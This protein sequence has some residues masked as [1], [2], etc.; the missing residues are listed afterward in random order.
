MH[1]SSLQPTL[2]GHDLEVYSVTWHPH[3]NVL[4]SGGTDRTVRVWDVAQGMLLATLAGHGHPQVRL[5]EQF[6]SCLLTTETLTSSFKRLY[7]RV[8]S[9]Y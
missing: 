1:S 4:A 3:G 5:C 8:G 7:I 9:V 6:V 2:E